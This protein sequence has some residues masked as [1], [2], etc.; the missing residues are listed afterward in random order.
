MT[1]SL[2]NELSYADVWPS[3]LYFFCVEPAPS[4]GETSLADSRRILAALD[5]QVV[6]TFR[7]RGIRYIRNLSP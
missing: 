6:D 5:P 4:G 7:A 3:R 1:L 2:H